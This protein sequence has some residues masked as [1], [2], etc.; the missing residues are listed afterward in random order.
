MELTSTIKEEELTP[1]EMEK[2]RIFY[3]PYRDK[4]FEYFKK[5]KAPK[6]VDQYLAAF[7]RAKIWAAGMGV[8]VLPMDIDDLLTCLIYVS[9]NVESYAAVKMAKYAGPCVGGTSAPPFFE[10]NMVSAP[11][12]LDNRGILFIFYYFF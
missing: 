12:F 7:E 11:P 10:E 8:S 9:E 1:Q 3:N 2:R 6:T 5:A 4:I